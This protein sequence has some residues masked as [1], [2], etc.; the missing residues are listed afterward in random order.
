MS[1][2]LADLVMRGI[3][4]SDA[5]I[6]LETDLRT[7][8]PVLSVGRRITSEDVADLLDEDAP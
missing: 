3:A 4:Q 6:E 8:L 1:S 5:Q 2:V 7:G